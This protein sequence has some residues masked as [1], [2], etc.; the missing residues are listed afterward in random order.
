MVEQVENHFLS[1]HL[2]P[3]AIFAFV[4]MAVEIYRHIFLKRMGFQPRSICFIAVVMPITRYFIGHDPPPINDFLDLRANF[5]KV[6][7]L[8]FLDSFSYCSVVIASLGA[9]RNP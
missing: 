1:V 6:Y 9:C 7:R 8:D 2:V 4:V 3:E 5:L